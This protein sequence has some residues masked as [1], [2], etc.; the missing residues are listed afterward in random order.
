MPEEVDYFRLIPELSG[1]NNGLG[2]DVDSWLSCNGSIQL[3]I[4]FSRLFWP[5]FTEHDGCILRAGFSPKT[6]A[7]FLA[8]CEG[9]RTA[10]EAVMNH[11]HVFD[12][13]PNATQMATG[14]QI[15]FLGRV[16]REIYSTKLAHDFPLRS[17]EVQFNEG[18]HSMT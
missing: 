9:D 5:Q 2:I 7:D 8:T 12:L 6:Y 11:V 3:A 15:Q 13:F 10:V 17:F 18:G 16:L 14:E 1:W 4:A